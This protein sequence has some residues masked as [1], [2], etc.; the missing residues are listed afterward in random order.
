MKTYEIDEDRE[1]AEYQTYCERIWN[2]LIQK[3]SLLGK[4]I[5][6]EQAYSIFNRIFELNEVTENEIDRMISKEL[7]DEDI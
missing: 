1:F 4:Q 5:N 6:E 2:H 7:K 3:L